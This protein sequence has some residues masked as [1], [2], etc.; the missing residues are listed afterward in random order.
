MEY[1]NK[2]DK[3]ISI[4]T[5]IF[6]MIGISDFIFNKEESKNIILMSICFGISTIL[7]LYL[8][9]KY[10]NNQYEKYYILDNPNNNNINNINNN[11]V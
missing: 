11:N 9:I 3:I 7:F 5:F 10:F 8:L 1:W 6:F 2:K 4:L